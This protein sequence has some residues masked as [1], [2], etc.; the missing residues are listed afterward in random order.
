MPLFDKKRTFF[1]RGMVSH[2][3]RKKF[4]H[5][6]EHFLGLV[7]CGAVIFPFEF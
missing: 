5:L 1:C 4:F 3:L 6:H 2:H 7:Y